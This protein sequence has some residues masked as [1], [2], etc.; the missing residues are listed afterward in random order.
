MHGM[1]ADIQRCSLHD[2]PGIRT[3]VFLK[4]CNLKCAWCHNPETIAFEPQYLLR[5]ER[6]IHCGECAKG[7]FSG[8]RVLCGRSATVEDVFAEVMLDK[9]FYG[10][11]GGVTLS[12]GEPMCQPDFTLALLKMCRESGIHTAIESNMSLPFERYERVL[13]YT[14]LL[15]ADLKILDAHLHRQYTGHDNAIIKRTI[16]AASAAGVPIVLH[17]PVIEGINDNAGEIGG[18]AA[19]A[20]TLPTLVCYELLPYHPLGLAKGSLEGSE[21]RRF[22]APPQAR[23]RELAMRAAG[24]NVPVKIAGETVGQE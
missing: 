21:P 22:A 15:L 12:G 9:P 1:I 5:P 13:P 19:F 23:L 2:G 6:C 10:S 3:T 8:A 14:G 11:E 7:C 20:A 18:I 16:Q 24:F 17:T 4:G